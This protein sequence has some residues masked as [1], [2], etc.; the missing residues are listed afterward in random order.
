MSTNPK[1]VLK[2][3]TS[4]SIR[5]IEVLGVP[6]EY[7]VVCILPVGKAVEDF[8]VPQKKAFEERVSFNRFGDR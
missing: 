7:D 5:S 8:K 4:T 1:N 2:I 6:E 3:D